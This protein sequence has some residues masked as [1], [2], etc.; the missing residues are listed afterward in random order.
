MSKK[1]IWDNGVP[2]TEEIREVRVEEPR[3]YDMRRSREFRQGQED[4][5]AGR[6]CLSNNGV[7]LDGWYDPDKKTPPYLLQEQIDAYCEPGTLKLKEK[8]GFVFN[9]LTRV[10]DNFG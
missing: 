3:P 2:Y 7:Y 9:P 8:K 10:W 4:R 1:I 5:R 6:A